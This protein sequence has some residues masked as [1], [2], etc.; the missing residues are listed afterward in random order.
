MVRKE[1]MNGTL[2]AAEL[3]GACSGS[4]VEV[5]LGTA[6]CSAAETVLHWSVLGCLHRSE[7]G[8]S[9]MTT[10]TCF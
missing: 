2:M 9:S 4:L 8:A 7:L 1:G 6:G 3:E 10:G 5:G